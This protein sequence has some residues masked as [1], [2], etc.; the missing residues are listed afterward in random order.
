M[1]SHYGPA[2]LPT[3]H[4]ALALAR[5]SIRPGSQT[6]YETGIRKLWE[7][8]SEYCPTLSFPLTDDD[9]AM[10]YAWNCERVSPDTASN[11]NSHVAFL[12]EV[13]LHIPRPVW[14]RLPLLQR[15]KRGSKLRFGKKRN[16]KQ[17]LT[18]RLGCK[19]REHS[20]LDPRTVTSDDLHMTIMTCITLTGIAGLFRLG[21]L[22]PKARKALDPERVIRHGQVSF[23]DKPDFQLA[24]TTFARVWLMKSKGDLYNEGTPVFVPAHPQDPLNCPVLW[25]KAVKRLSQ[26]SFPTNTTPMFTLPN[27]KLM[28]KAD[29]TTW[30]KATLRAMGYDP[31]AYAGHSLRIGGAVSAQRCGVPEHIIQQMGRWRSQ[32]YR[33]YTRYEPA[34]IKILRCRLQHL[35]SVQRDSGRRR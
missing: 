22:L 31:R 30:L 32:A 35:K 14:T 27:G 6:V 16:R 9:W 21:E 25:L 10:F 26:T 13:T 4:N 12:Q 18:W 1:P 5:N 20:G 23:F 7:F 3:W 33:L 2:A 8:A 29:F 11:Y 28:R 24:G 15:V 19:I 17:P 34:Q